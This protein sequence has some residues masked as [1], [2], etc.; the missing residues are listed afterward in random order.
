MD[1]SFASMMCYFTA[2]VILLVARRRRP[3]SQ[4]IHRTEET[5]LER[6]GSSRNLQ[7]S[8]LLEPQPGSSAIWSHG[9]ISGSTKREGAL[10][11]LPKSGM[12]EFKTQESRTEESY[13]YHRI[14]L[15]FVWL[16]VS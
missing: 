1:V 12:Q 6:D 8:V 2:V 11:R 4:D 9:L 3:V 14:R 13:R 16:R 7:V 15:R 10:F 5:E